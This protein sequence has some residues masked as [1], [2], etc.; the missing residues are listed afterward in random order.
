MRATYLTSINSHDWDD[1]TQVALL[2]IWRGRKSYDS[3]QPLKPWIKTCVGRTYINFIQSRIFYNNILDAKYALGKRNIQHPTP[4]V[5]KSVQLDS[6]G[7]E[8]LCYE[9]DIASVEKV[10][11]FV[12]FSNIMN[13]PSPKGDGFP[14]SSNSFGVVQRLLRVVPTLVF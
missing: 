9:P 10:D 12:E 13:Y 2:N 5:T 7:N 14:L 4:I 1:I 11:S 8:E 3:K 6:C